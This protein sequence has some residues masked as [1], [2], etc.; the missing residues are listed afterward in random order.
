M[1][2]L[3]CRGCSQSANQGDTALPKCS[4]SKEIVFACLTVFLDVTALETT[5]HKPHKRQ[6]QFALDVRA[7]AMRKRSCIINLF[8]ET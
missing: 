2:K 1:K 6:Q 7:C 8:T 4:S 3:I 5:L